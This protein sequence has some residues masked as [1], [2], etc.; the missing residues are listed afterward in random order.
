MT[1]SRVASD[2]RKSVMRLA[3][4]GATAG[5]MPPE[6]QQML[7]SRWWAISS[8]VKPRS[9]IRRRTAS[10]MWGAWRAPQGS[11]D[12]K[13]PGWRGGNPIRQAN[14]PQHFVDGAGV[15]LRKKFLKGL[16]AVRAGHDDFLGS[17]LRD[18]PGHLADDPEHH[19]FFPHEIAGG[20][21]TVEHDARI[22]QPAAQVGVSRLHDRGGVARQGAAREKD[23][24]RL[25]G[26]G[27]RAAQGKGRGSA[28]LDVVPDALMR[29]QR[30]LTPGHQGFP[31]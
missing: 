7:R 1:R 26:G 6:P 14:L 23:P 9:A 24:G 15:D 30:P 4:S 21:A 13:S 18:F 16:V 12:V 2:K 20:A 31:G 25:A 28:P 29:G 27:V 22:R 8:T 3:S 17:Q 5:A 19:V 10:W 11:L